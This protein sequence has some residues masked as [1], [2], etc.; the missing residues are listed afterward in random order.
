M[1]S[2]SAPFLVASRSDAIVGHAYG[3]M[4]ARDWDELLDACGEPHDICVEE[5]FR[6]RGVRAAERPAFARTAAAPP[7]F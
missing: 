3:R 6:T 1:T 7:G 4:E 2:S 5:A